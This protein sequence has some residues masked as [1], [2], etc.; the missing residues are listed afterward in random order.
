MPLLPS[1]FSS[2]AAMTA[3]SSIGLSEQV[4]YTI[5]PPTASCSTPRTAIRSWS[6][7][8]THTHRLCH[9]A[10]FSTHSSVNHTNAQILA[11]WRVHKHTPSPLTRGGAGCCWSSISST[12]LCSSALCRPR[13]GNTEAPVRHIPVWPEALSPLENPNS[14]HRT[15]LSVKH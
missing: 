9:T 8:N 11:L 14:S 2:R 10:N 13:C 5:L 3:S 12:R 4:E 15:K 1:L 6:L 7:V